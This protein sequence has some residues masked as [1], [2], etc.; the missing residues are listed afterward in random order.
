MSE[1][2]ELLRRNRRCHSKIKKFCEPLFNNFGF[3]GI[4]YHHIAANGYAT[5]CSSDLESFEYYYQ[6]DLYKLNPYARHPDFFQSGIHFIPEIKNDAYQNA[7]QSEA[8]KFDM[9]YQLVILEKS[10]IG[11]QGFSFAISQ[12]DQSSSYSYIINHLA[13]LQS[14]IRYFK[15]ENRRLLDDL[16]AE[17]Y[18]LE[19]EIGK[20][21]KNRPNFFLDVPSNTKKIEMLKQLGI[22][23]PFDDLLLSPREKECIRL[24]IK[25]YTATQT[26]EILQLSKRTVEHYLENIKLKTNSFSKLELF[27]KFRELEALGLLE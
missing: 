19:K 2:A 5:S 8:D 4:F 16:I 26:G 6:A 21:F 3:K 13:I 20:E 1:L 15:K 17:P 27:E 14:F 24:L 23:D 10:A 11:C 25:G 7:I 18:N 22:I 9:S 12:K